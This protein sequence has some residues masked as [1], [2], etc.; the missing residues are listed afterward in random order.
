MPKNRL[1][2]IWTIPNIIPH[3]PWLF[4]LFL[5]I[6]NLSPELAISRKKKIAL[7]QATGGVPK[8]IEP[9]LKDLIQLWKM[10]KTVCQKILFL[11]WGVI[12]WKSQFACNYIMHKNLKSRCTQKL[13]LCTF[14]R[15]SPIKK[16]WSLIYRF[17]GLPWV[18]IY[19]F[20]V[21]IP[22]ILLFS[23]FIGPESSKIQ[24]GFNLWVQCLIYKIRKK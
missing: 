15:N 24:Y 22:E 3:G 9:I 12:F 13:L 19:R 20:D 17:I 1:R 5:W 21:G 7:D 6:S 4:W 11:A 18:N 2:N 14:L 23:D 8:H 16:F 10:L